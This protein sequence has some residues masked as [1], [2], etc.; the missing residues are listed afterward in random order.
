MKI[1][2]IFQPSKGQPERL[3]SA[4]ENPSK[5]ASEGGVKG[6]VPSPHARRWGGLDRKDCRVRDGQR[7]VNEPRLAGAHGHAVGSAQPYRRAPDS[8]P[9]ASNT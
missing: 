3:A 7:A 5:S 1:T 8:A 6:K 4:N 9:A 2:T